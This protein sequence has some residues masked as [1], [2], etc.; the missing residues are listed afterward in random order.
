MLQGRRSCAQSLYAGVGTMSRASHTS[1]LSPI[2]RPCVCRLE[3]K[4]GQKALCAYTT[5][6]AQVLSAHTQ[7]RCFKLAMCN[8]VTDAALA[9]LPPTLQEM[10]LVACGGVHGS[11]LCRLTRLEVL[12]LS[13]CQ[14]ITKEAA[15]QVTPGSQTLNWCKPCMT[16]FRCGGHAL[17]R[18]GCS[19]PGSRCVILHPATIIEVLGPAF[20]ASYIQAN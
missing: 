10:H 14:S 7:L 6:L 19:P 9:H 8:S 15:K 16:S 20:L 17:C 13:S 18:Y 5:W 12:R 1:L 2:M 3:G 11:C 4:F